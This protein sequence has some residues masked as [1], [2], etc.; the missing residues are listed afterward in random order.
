MKYGYI[1]FVLDDDS[2][3]LL[4][5]QFP[6]LYPD[7][8]AHHI[9]YAFHVPNKNIPDTPTDIHVIGQHDNGEIQ[10]LS[11]E[12]DG[13]NTQTKRE[14][15]ETRY[16]HITMSL[17]RAKGHSPNDANDILQKIVEQ[18]GESALSN[19]ETPV[20]IT[21]KPTWTERPSE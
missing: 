9:T 14:D 11:V 16:L 6:A 1:S 5:R 19:L 2:R 10:V 21:A 7:I 12:I 17:N 4:L 3:N 18:H 13:K 8:I 15:D 20:N